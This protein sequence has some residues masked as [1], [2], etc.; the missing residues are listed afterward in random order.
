MARILM[1]GDGDRKTPLL[2][3]TFDEAW[4]LRNAA[5]WAVVKRMNQATYWEAEAAEQGDEFQFKGRTISRR[6]EAA[7][8]QKLADE[9]SLLVAVL[10][11]YIEAGPLSERGGGDSCMR[12]SSNPGSAGTP[13]TPGNFPGPPKG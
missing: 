3:L 4:N 9:Y 11:E 2:E 8:E 12:S 13:S 6:K 1:S 7:K 10:R 5:I